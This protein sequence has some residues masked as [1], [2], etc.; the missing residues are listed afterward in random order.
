MVA[1]DSLRYGSEGEGEIMKLYYSDVLTKAQAPSTAFEERF[2]EC[3]EQL[4]N[5]WS[6]L[7][8]VGLPAF[9]VAPL[10]RTSMAVFFQH[11]NHIVLNQKHTGTYEADIVEGTIPH[12]LAHYAVWHLWEKEGALSG[13]RRKRVQAHGVQWRYVMRKVFHI[14]NPQAKHID[15]NLLPYGKGYEYACA[16]RTHI[17]SGVKH[18]RILRGAG[19]YECRLCRTRLIF[20]AKKG[21]QQ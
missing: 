15:A 16:C 5:T 3:G 14:D 8:T 19:E 17:L 12:E 13:R 4:F 11:K 20:I 10:P 2:H 21:K 6:A 9:H 18:H 1:P 7:K